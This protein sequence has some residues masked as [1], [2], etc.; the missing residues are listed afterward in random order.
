MSSSDS[1][2]EPSTQ[3][4]P[5]P[6]LPAEGEA[7]RDGLI[8]LLGRRKLESTAIVAKVEGYDQDLVQKVLPTVIS[9]FIHNKKT[10]DQARAELIREA[11]SQ[12]RSS[13][14]FAFEW[15]DM[16]KNFIRGF[17]TS[18]PSSENE[19]QY[20]KRI[21]GDDYLVTLNLVTSESS[22]NA[23][24]GTYPRQLAP[25]GHSMEELN[26]AVEPVREYLFRLRDQRVKRLKGKQGL[27][28]KVVGQDITLAKLELNRLKW[29]KE[30]Q[31]RRSASKNP[32][33]KRPRLERK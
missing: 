12:L 5:I 22:S 27:Q 7:L 21:F 11:L 1:D 18:A 25:L 15:N 30:G 28:R 3:P 10:Q 16:Y 33:V 13:H 2:S 4:A 31:A 32:R 17:K 8:K 26:L 19:I 6:F 29:T 24:D 20:V 14:K 23:E 9:R